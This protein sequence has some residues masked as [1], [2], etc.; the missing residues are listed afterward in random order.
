MI[1]NKKE[2]EI[3][4]SISFCGLFSSQLLGCRT[5]GRMTKMDGIRQH[6]PFCGPKNIYNEYHFAG[7]TMLLARVSGIFSSSFFH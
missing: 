7:S 2:T 6:P 4:F 1:R 5:Y 3:L